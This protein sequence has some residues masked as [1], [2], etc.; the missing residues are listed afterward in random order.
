MV[1][2]PSRWAADTDTAGSPTLMFSA[3]A[4][5]DACGGLPWYTDPLPFAPPA[6]AVPRLYYSTTE[7]RR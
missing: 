2:L 4:R 3:S 6:R 7:A 1:S 5:A